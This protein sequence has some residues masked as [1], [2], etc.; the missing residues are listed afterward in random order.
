MQ[1]MGEVKSTV[2]AQLPVRNWSFTRR[3]IAN[4]SNALRTR[5]PTCLSVLSN[6]RVV[7]LQWTGD[8][9]GMMISSAYAL[10]PKMLP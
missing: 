1:L 7:S 8:K 10:E 4:A 6:G 5:R 2:H 9:E 3:I